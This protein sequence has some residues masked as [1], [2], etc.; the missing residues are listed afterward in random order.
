[1]V[2]LGEELSSCLLPG[3]ATSLHDYHCG[4][5]APGRDIDNVHV[6][7]ASGL[8]HVVTST[9]G[10]DCH[11]SLFSMP[12]AIG[13]FILT[14]RDMKI[15][16]RGKIYSINEGYAGSW[17]PAVK[18]YVESKKFPKVSLQGS[19]LQPLMFQ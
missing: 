11:P 12:Q 6:S 18:E 2:S 3:C 10:Q 4:G 19:G 15:K 13:E 16:P 8:L 7:D 17:D 9:L 14:D 1:M 5:L